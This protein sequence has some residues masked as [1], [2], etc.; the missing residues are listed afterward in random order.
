MDHAEF[1]ELCRDTSVLLGFEDPDAMGEEGEFSLDGVEMSLMLEDTAEDEEAE[2]ADL[3]I[4]MGEVE[5][6]RE[7][8]EKMLSMN[9]AMDP[10][11]QGSLGLDVESRHAVMTAKIPLDTGID[12]ESLA[13]LLRQFAEWTH[14]F[15]EEVSKGGG[16]SL[17]Q[18]LPDFAPPSFA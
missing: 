18:H 6:S 14:R 4:D 5:D 10:A 1:L 8:Y 2:G 15:R 17:P 12:A 9:L 3:L 7:V 16:A 11:N 13:D